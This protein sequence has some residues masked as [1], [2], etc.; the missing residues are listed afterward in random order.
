[1][2]AD[3]V[4]V[5]FTYQNTKSP[6]QGSYDVA[7]LN[8]TFSNAMTYFFSLP[9]TS[10]HPGNAP[11]TTSTFAVAK[12][13]IFNKFS[14]VSSSPPLFILFFS[15]NSPGTGLPPANKAGN[16]TRCKVLRH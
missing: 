1:M 12:K 14:A 2:L 13:R 15:V 8:C 5:L 4:L 10:Q 9:D 6:R 3:S 7:I 11:M 16:P